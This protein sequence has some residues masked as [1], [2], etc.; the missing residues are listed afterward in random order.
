MK[1]CAKVAALWGFVSNKLTKTIKLCK[2]N[3]DL[4]LYIKLFKEL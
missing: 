3:S 1:S 4:K 2:I